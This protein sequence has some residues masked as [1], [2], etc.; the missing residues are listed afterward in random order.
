[1]ER[2]YNLGTM[3]KLLWLAV[4]LGLVLGACSGVEGDPEMTTS[5]VEPEIMVTPYHTAAPVQTQ[6]P[7]QTPTPTL[8]PPPLPTPTPFLHIVAEGE[9]MIGIA[10]YYGVSL[11]ALQV[12]NP[13]VN[14]NFL[15]VGAQLVIPLE[16]EDGEA[17]LSLAE[18]EIMPV[19]GGE[20]QCFPNRGEG[21]WCFWP[22]T[23]SLDKPVENL[24]G[25]MH[26]YDQE[27]EVLLSQPAY[28]LVNLLK[29]GE[30]VVLG[31]YFKA[32]LPDWGSAQGQVTSA[33]AANRAEER[34]LGTE[35]AGLRIEPDEDGGLAARVSGTV[36]ITGLDE[37]VWPTTLWVLAMAYDDA[38]Q[39]V[40]LHRWEAAEE[41]LGDTVDFDFMV[42]SA[43]RPIA[44]VEILAE[45]RSSV[46]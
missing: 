43:G 40:G 28:S 27:G 30:M 2:W 11:E 7:T 3:R 17:S 41:D 38:G 19:A 35:V 21:M 8:T 36:L 12:A 10:G 37:G 22:L 1:M 16:T 23:N 13:D 34:Y 31:T 33:T 46:P 24:A 5:A 29:P 44:R 39:A 26:L 9:T 4:V 14:A 20:V 25:L 45:A 18:P 6:A 42:Y 15:S 32:P